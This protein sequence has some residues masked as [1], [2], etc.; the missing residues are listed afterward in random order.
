[1]ASSRQHVMNQKFD[2]TRQRR[3]S[4]VSNRS[5]LLTH[6]ALNLL[7][8]TLNQVDH[9]NTKP[10]LVLVAQQKYWDRLAKQEVDVI[11]PRKPNHN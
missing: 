11:D 10:E 3:P 2:V 5:R 8:Q 4:L 6:G 7:I 1:M 9:H